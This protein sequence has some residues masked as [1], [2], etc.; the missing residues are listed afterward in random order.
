MQ[1]LQMCNKQGS[2]GAARPW[3]AVFDDFLTSSGDKLHHQ[4]ISLS[5]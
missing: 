5:M 2:V 1:T 4:G 3:R